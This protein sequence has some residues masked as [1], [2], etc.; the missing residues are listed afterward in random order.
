MGCPLTFK[1]F[2]PIDE[3]EDAWAKMKEM[4]FNGPT[5]NIDKHVAHFKSLLTKTRM[6]DSTAII[7]FFRETL[8]RG[9]QQKIIML[10]NVPENLADWYKWATKI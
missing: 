6:M 3:T 4:R 10:P 9:L 7:N 2:K 1:A 8:P 5:R